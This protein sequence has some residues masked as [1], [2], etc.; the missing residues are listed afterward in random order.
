MNSLVWNPALKSD[1]SALFI[2][3][4]VCIAIKPTTTSSFDW[5]NAPN[6]TI[7]S[8]TSWTSSVPPTINST[9]TAS[10]QQ[11]GIPSSCQSFYKAEAVSHRPPLS[12]LS[13]VLTV[14]PRGTPAILCS[15]LTLTSPWSC[16]TSG[17]PRST[18]TARG[19]GPT[20]GTVWLIT[21]RQICPS[22]L[23]SL[24][25]VLPWEMAPSVAAKRG[26]RRPV[27]MTATSLPRL[28]VPFPR[29]TLSLGT[30]R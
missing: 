20:T 15:K 4:Y 26:T 17:I 13:V 12:R 2:G 25:P 24:H 23:R 18:A 16:F 5:F 14:F 21:T 19:S 27:A 3:F 10:P 1:C 28:S 22:H 8:P 9:F 11:S 30:H 6:T 7:P 29:Q